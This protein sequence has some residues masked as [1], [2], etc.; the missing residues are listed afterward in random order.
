MTINNYPIVYNSNGTVAA[1]LDKAY[2]VLVKDQYITRTKGY[3]TLEFTIPFDYN[4]REYVKSERIVRVLD[5][6][7]VIK[8]INDTRAKENIT[9]VECDALWYDLADGELFTH[10]AT[11]YWTLEAAL[12]ELLEGTG[13]TRGVTE[14]TQTHGYT[15]S[16]PNNRLWSLR[17]IHKVFGGRLVFDT[18]NKTVNVYEGEGERTNNYF[19]FRSNLA[20][21]TRRIDTTELFTRVYMY[22]QDGVTIGQINNGIDYVEN[23]NW[24]DEQGLERKL[25]IYVIEDE[26]FNNLYYMKAYMEQYLEQYSK[27]LLSYEISMAYLQAIPNL[28]DFVYVEDLELGVSGWYE[29]LERTIDVLEPWKTIL[30]LESLVQD[31]TSD[32]VTEEN[33]SSDDVTDAVSSVV[34]NMSPYNLLFNSRGEDGLN[35]WVSSGFNVIEGGQSGHNSFVNITGTTTEKTLSQRVYP[36]TKS[37]YTLSAYVEAPDNYNYDEDDIIGFRVITTYEDGTTQ[38]DFVSWFGN[39]EAEEDV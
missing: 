13:W 33:L 1:I 38:E 11:N 14:I 35:Y 16:E 21:M 23:Y 12:D 7:Y 19:S 4:K 27:P 39:I 26:R 6:D 31:L 22:G 17:Y 8:V 2:N 30:I 29:V 36:S 3:E 24:Y 37:S 20:G 15:I 18:I 32:L 9:T 5:R 10:T 25:K 28:N 34:G